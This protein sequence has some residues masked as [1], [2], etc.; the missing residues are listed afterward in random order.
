MIISFLLLNSY[1]IALFFLYKGFQRILEIPTKQAAS[2]SHP[3]V[4]FTIIIPFRN[5]AA[6]LPALIHSLN[7]LKFPK[8]AFEIIFVDDASN[9][10]SIN[11]IK[12]NIDASIKFSILKNIPTSN[13]PKK[14]AI[15]LAVSKAKHTWILTTD[16][17]CQVPINWLWEYHNAINAFS[18][19]MLCAPVAIK[20]SKGFMA[21]FQQLDTYSLQGVTMGSFGINRPIMCNGANLGFNKEAFYKVQGYKGNNHIASG[22]DVFLLEKMNATFPGQVHFIKSNAAVVTT[23]ALKSWGAIINQRVRWASKTSKVKNIYATALGLLVL[24][25]NFLC[26]ALLLLGFI[27]AVSWIG[28][29]VFIGLKIYADGLFVNAIKKWFNHK[30]PFIYLLRAGF[31]YPFVVFIVSIKSIRGKYVWKDRDY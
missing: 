16:A 3:I 29:T 10:T 27:K 28:V 1:L 23:R 2:Q 26:I 17:D 19:T 5:E 13:A 4:S 24:I 20:N 18:P 6:Q 8:E 14:D 11:V 22:D 9:D 7:T 15:T 31:V 25:V 21:Q 12:S 30:L